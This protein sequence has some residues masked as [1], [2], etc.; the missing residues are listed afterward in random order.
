[1]KRILFSLLMI[2]LLCIGAM[3]AET[4]YVDGTVAESGDGLTAAAAFKTLPEAIAAVDA[5]GT[6]IVSGNITT[7]TSASVKADKGFT[8]TSANGAVL[9]LGRNLYLGGDTVIENIALVN[10]AAANS[11]IIY[12]C[13]HD[14]TIGDGV[15]V[16]PHA[17]NGRYL[18]L[19]AGQY[20]GDLVGSGT[21]TVNSGTWRN[22]FSG[23]WNDAYT[24][25]TTIIMNGGSIFRVDD[26][27]GCIKAGNIGSGSS[28]TSAVTVIVNGGTVPY[29][30]D[31]LKFT[32]TCNV[33]VTGGEVA[34][35]K[36]NTTVDLTNGGSAK[37]GSCE[38]VVTTKAADGYEVIVSNGVYTAQVIPADAPEKVYVDGTLS[39]SGDGLTPET[40]VKTL[41]EAATMLR[42]GGTIVVCGDTDNFSSTTLPARPAILITSVDGE[43][44]YTDTAEINFKAALH[45]GG[46]TTFKDVVLEYE[47]LDGGNIYIYGEG[48]HLTMDTGVSCLNYTGLNYLSLVGA[49]Y[50]TA[51]EGDTHITVKSG[52]FRN[53]YGGNVQADFKGNTKIEVTGGTVNLTVAGG[54]FKGNF[55][56]STDIYFGGEAALMYGVNA[57]TG[58]VGGTVGASSGTVYTFKGDVNIT[59]AGK[60]GVG[61]AIYGASRYAKVTHTG[62]VNITVN[63]NVYCSQPLYAAGNCATFNGNT[64][65]TLN[66]GELE[67]SI[68]GGSNA[69]TM[70]G[71]AEIIING[72]RFVYQGSA[73]SASNI[74]DFGASNIYGSGASKSTLNGNVTVT[75]NGGVIYGDVLGDSVAATVSEDTDSSEDSDSVAGDMNEGTTDDTTDATGTGSVSGTKTVTVKG[76]TIYGIV[77]NANVTVDLSGGTSVDL[78]ESSKI[79][80]LIGGGKLIVLGMTK[81][82]VGTLTGAVDYVIKGVPLPI[83]YIKVGTMGEGAVINY[84]AQKAETLAAADGVYSIDF[85]GAH[86]TTAVTVNFNEGWICE[87]YAGQTLNTVRSDS[88]V[89]AIAADASTATSATYTLTPGLYSAHVRVSSSNYHRQYF[90]VFGD[91]ETQ[92]VDVLFDK[93][94]GNGYERKDTKRHNKEVLELYYDNSDIDG[95]FVSDLP[96]FTEEGRNKNVFTSAEECNAYV[97]ALDENCGYMY[98]FVM[99]QT[100]YHNLDFPV[101][102]FT[103]DEIPAGA[104]IEEIAEIVGKTKGRDIIQISA[105]VHGNEPSGLDG[106]LTFMA[107][108]C[109]EEYA[110]TVFDN[111]NIGA[112]VILPMMSPEGSY[113]HTRNTKDDPY[114]ANPN[115][116]YFSIQATGTSLY[117]YVGRLFMPTATV[118]MHEMTGRP[119][120]AVNGILTDMYDVGI[121]FLTPLHNSPQVD[122]QAALMGDRNA[123]QD[124]DG[125]NKLYEAMGILE[126]QGIRPYYYYKMITPGCAQLYSANSFGAYAFIIESTAVQMGDLLHD[127]HV[128]LHVA[129]LKAYMQ[130]ILNSEGTMAAKVIA[131]REATR[132]SAQQYND[133]TP[134]VVA[135]GRSRSYDYSSPWNNPLVHADGTMITE[136]NPIRWYT[137]DTADRYRTRPT[138][139]VFPAEVTN[140]AKILE[141]LDRHG[142]AYHKLD[143]GTTL[144][145]QQYGGTAATPKLGAAKSVTF[146]T[147]AYIVPVDGYMANTIS[148]LFEPDNADVGADAATTFVQFGLLVNAEIYRSTES[149]IAAKLGLA[150]TY[151][152]VEIPAEKTVVSAVVDGTA[153]DSV[154]TEDASAFIVASDKEY[155]KATLTFADGS[156]KLYTIG[157]RLGDLSGDQELDVQDVLLFIRGL[158]NET[159]A[160]ETGDI[161]E[162]GKV[163]IADVIRLMKWIVA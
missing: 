54:N 135:H 11:D 160:K 28:N 1:M 126:E 30:R 69:G 70:N 60:A 38:G 96:Y 142:I 47:K 32:G 143:A 67:K 140:L 88:P 93:A 101:V 52:H 134:I 5:G 20:E 78:Y 16:T 13:G 80:T 43:N 94:E 27:N 75:M 100:K 131:G 103:K 98:S 76:G 115:R 97:K 155:Y 108:L 125:E 161:N 61:S 138:A 51:F 24:G 110:K 50:D 12:A 3:A 157:T 81:L 147:G 137:Q 153:Y 77:G 106:V 19:A 119:N 148:I 56:G 39:A 58:F 40:A 127:R 117:S 18:L 48:H 31:G 105:A 89:P 130:V 139:Y 21:I 86:K 150:G 162:D 2:A 59:L 154:P 145:L 4:V 63:D 123:L 124:I 71:D 129:A 84:T 45:L 90:Y 25:T 29:I 107:E 68:Y 6:V 99:G 114:N 83:E 34:K 152:A 14:L 113:S 163:N 87:V 46:D 102:V 133:R 49:G 55:E 121:N 109:K 79:N 15:T 91:Q 42:N 116:A 22:I 62:N 37:L 73:T 17:S 120:Y 85:D 23:N 159:L 65:I 82:D 128:Y 57:P 72:G 10:G 104:S 35:S 95:F 149:F 141:I 158:V 122:T 132:L 118:D 112:I 156:T 33:T 9:T 146:D 36:Y 44:D 92:T 144:T 66:G 7:S 64:K 53:I 136:T 26:S 41:Y 111:T 151:S 8:L 74:P